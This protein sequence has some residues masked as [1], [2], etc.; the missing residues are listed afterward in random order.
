[1][2]ISYCRLA[3]IAGAASMVAIGCAVL[4]PLAQDPLYH[5]FA[6]GRTLYGVP[7]FWNVISNVP[8]FLVALYGIGTF[9]SG[10]AFV[11]PWER[12]AYCVLLGATAAVGVGSIYYHL[13]PDNPRLFW[14]RLPMTDRKSTRLNS[15]HLVISY[16]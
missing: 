13:H 16:A 11:E 8:F 4:P 5:A 7:N 6:D 9:R 12:I 2:A 10:T 1:M 15:S 3:T 14:D